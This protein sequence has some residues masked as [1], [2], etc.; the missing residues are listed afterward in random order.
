MKTV[1]LAKDFGPNLGKS[2]HFNGHKRESEPVQH[3]Q[4]DNHNLTP[5]QYL[6]LRDGL[7]RQLDQM[8]SYRLIP[9]SVVELQAGL[10]ILPYIGKKYVLTLTNGQAI[11][12]TTA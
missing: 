4:L 3:Y 7:L 6:L 8:A 2:I 12:D 9:T 10:K 5:P 1:V 11:V